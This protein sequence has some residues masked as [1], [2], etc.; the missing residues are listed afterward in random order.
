MN[1][2]SRINYAFSVNISGPLQPK[3][4]VYRDF[5][6]HMNIIYILLLSLADNHHPPQL[7]LSLSASFWSIEEGQTGKLTNRKGTVVRP[8]AKGVGSGRADASTKFTPNPDVNLRKGRKSAKGTGPTGAF[9]RGWAPCSL[10]L[11]HSAPFSF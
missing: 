10:S 4:A 7:K 5:S 6:R 1:H 11:L 3:D 9:S 8:Q 2:I